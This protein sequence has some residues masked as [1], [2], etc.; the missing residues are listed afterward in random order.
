MWA[1]RFVWDRDRDFNC[2]RRRLLWCKFGVFVSINSDFSVNLHLACRFVWF[3]RI[4]CMCAQIILNTRAL[5]ENQKSPAKNQNRYGLLLPLLLWWYRYCCRFRR[6]RRCCMCMC[7]TATNMSCHSLSASFFY[8]WNVRY[9]SYALGLLLL[10]LLLMALLLYRWYVFGG[11]HA[12][13]VYMNLILFC[14]WSLLFFLRLLLFAE[15]CRSLYHR[16]GC[17]H[18]QR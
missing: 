5:H 18:F 4:D 10:P 12:C 2:G 17:F 6:C 11:F 9:I 8:R 14:K 16:F 15:Q 3:I 1:A 7:S 13:C